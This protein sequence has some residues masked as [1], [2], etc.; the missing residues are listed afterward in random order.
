MSFSRGAAPAATKPRSPVRTVSVDDV[1]PS[2][3]QIDVASSGRL[4]SD[5]FYSTCSP[6]WIA[7]ARCF[8]RRRAAS[9]FFRRRRSPGFSK[10]ARRFKSCRIPSLSTNRLK[11]RI[12]P[13]TPRSPTVT[14]NGRRRGAFPPSEVDASQPDPPRNV[15]RASRATP[16][17]SMGPR[18]QKTKA[19]RG[20]G[21]RGAG[22]SVKPSEPK[23]TATLRGLPPLVKGNPS[24]RAQ[25]H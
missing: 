3:R 1:K 11:R 14:S 18:V 15:M 2:E 19:P 9:R 20:L 10:W 23:A 17:V 5:H 24:P 12:A 8:R 21:P 6:R 25:G 7:R 16:P 22:K 13:S 4:P